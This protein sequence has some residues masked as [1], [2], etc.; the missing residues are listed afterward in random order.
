MHKSLF[1]PLM[2]ATGILVCILFYLAY[3]DDIAGQRSLYALSSIVSFLSE[4]VRPFVV[5]V[6]FYVAW[7]AAIAIAI[8]L[9]IVALGRSRSHVLFFLGVTVALATQFLLIDETSRMALL[10]LVGRAP[11]ST[12]SIQAA[13]WIGVS[14]YVSAFGLL[15]WSCIQPSAVGLD[16]LRARPQRRS[17]VTFGVLF[18]A[19]TIGA[20]FRVYALNQHLN[21]FE[22]E[23]APY[24]AG[25]TSLSGMIYANRGYNG[26]WAPLGLLYY[27]P[28][29]LTTELYGTTLLALRLSSA[30]VGIATIPLVYLLANKIAGRVAG[31]FATTLFALNCLHIGWSRTDIHPHGVTTWPTLL[32]CFFLLRAAETRSVVWALGVALMMGLAWHQYPSGQ[33]AVA[34]PLIAVGFS[35]LVNWGAL[36]LRRWQLVCIVLGVG[37]WILGLPLSYY[38]VDGQFKF[39][40]PF[41]LTGPRALWGAEGPITSTW[42]MAL[43]VLLKTASHLWDFIQGVFFKVPY[44]FHQEWLPYT[45]PLLSRSVPWFV[46]SLAMTAV[47]IL[48]AQRKRF[49]TAVLLGWFIAGLLPGV[50]SSH[51]YPKRLSTVFPLIDILAGIGF[52]FGY[53]YLRRCRFGISRLLGSGLALAS[54]LSLLLY[55]NFVWFSKVFFRYGEPPELAMAR[56]LQETIAPKTLVIAGLG[57]GYEPGKFLYLMLDHLTAPANRPNLFVLVSNGGLLSLASKRV[58]DSDQIAMSLPYTWTRLD[59]QVTESLA[60]TDWENVTFIILKTLHN[61]PSNAEAVSLVES[62]CT[63]PVVRLVPS[64]VNTPEWEHVTIAAITCKV[65]DLTQP[66]TFMPSGRLLEAATR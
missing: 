49:E 2:A 31:V 43:Y 15:L 58:L 46:V 27:L 36:P 18:V 55:S 24:S 59:R 39:L 44:L 37:L 9:F 1:A 14:G 45:P 62:M 30:L 63:N 19:I 64:S 11:T 57:G 28:I 29:Y 54:C 20:F 41:T 8:L 60:N 5:E 38:P 52:A 6:R 23:L 32:M 17:V 61:N 66:I 51:A 25:G 47:A 3:L 26:P 34:I 4:K 33:S 12:A 35:F 48:L 21:L 22:G 53:E 13:I 50:L 65:A 7:S 10:Q 16:D 40:N 42:Q 56:K